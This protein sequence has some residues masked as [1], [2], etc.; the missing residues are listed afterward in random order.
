M[1]GT[2]RFW[3]VHIQIDHNR[4]LSVPH[5]HRFADFIWAGIDLLVRHIGWN[6]N[7]IARLGFLASPW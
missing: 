5:D 6:V 7:K 2:G 4:I 1:S 3:G